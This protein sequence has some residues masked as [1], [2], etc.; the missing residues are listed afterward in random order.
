MLIVSA[1]LSDGRSFRMLNVLG[2][3]NREGLAIEVDVSLPALRVARAL[4][5]I[6][7]QRGRPKTIRVDNGPEYVSGTLQT[8]AKKRG[9]ALSYIQ[10]DKPQQNACV[11]RYNRTVRQEWLGQYLFETIDQ[12]REHAARWL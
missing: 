2:D 6:I 7:E 8:W 9:I 3:F 1:Q 10:P 11:E 12:V 5:R 4:D